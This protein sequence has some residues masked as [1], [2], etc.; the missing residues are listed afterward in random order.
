MSGELWFVSAQQALGDNRLVR[1]EMN[2]A[3]H[4]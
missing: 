3:I 1:I 4:E 2:D